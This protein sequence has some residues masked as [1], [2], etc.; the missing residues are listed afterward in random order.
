MFKWFKHL[1]I[2]HEGNSHHPHLWRL[3]SVFL[4]LTIIAVFQLATLTQ[5]FFN[6][7]KDSY[8]SAILPAVVA[9]LTNT[10]RSAYNAHPL[11][12]NSL[13]DEAA[14]LKAKDMAARGYFSH[15]T[16]EGLLP[17]HFLNKVGYRYVRA[18]ENLAVNFTDSKDVVNAW[19]NSP[20]H[21]ANIT[22]ESF[23]EIGI[24]MADGFHQGQPT[25][26][27]VQFF[28]TPQAAVQTSPPVPSTTL[29]QATTNPSALNRSGTNTTTLQTTS[30]NRPPIATNTS[31]QRKR[32]VNENL[33]KNNNV[34][35]STTI[36]L[37]VTEPIETFKTNEL[38]YIDSISTSP[39]HFNFYFL[40]ALLILILISLLVTV[41]TSK[42]KLHHPKIISTAL[43]IALIIITF[44][45]YNKIYMKNS[46]Q[47]PA[48]GGTGIEVG[49]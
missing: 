45:I 30:A 43:I 25:I 26:F 48:E 33:Q 49:I 31:S 11:I 17:W 19:M 35:G 15:N 39:R 13:L 20:T 4:I 9:S 34:L 36:D 5:S 27:V 23:T 1:L 28:A 12:R 6:F 44:L 16:P 40:T 2:P 3:K 22:K 18:G 46:I 21:K 32:S 41:L 37:P 29:N 42:N 7:K 10:E 8:L 38:T 24:G 47:L 14:T